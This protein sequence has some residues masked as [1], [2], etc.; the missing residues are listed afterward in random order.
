MPSTTAP[1]L[2]EPF[3]EH[4]GEIRKLSTLLEASQALSTTLD[5]RTGL[6]LVLA[7]LSR[8]HGAVRSTVVLRNERSGDVEVEAS[9]P[10][11]Q[12]SRRIRYSVGEGITRKVLQTGKPV[13]VPRV[14]EEPTFLNRAAARPE[15]PEQELTYI[16]API[17]L[18]GRTIGAIGVDLRF[19]PDRDYHRTVKFLGVVGSMIAQA[20]KLYGLLQAER[21]AAAGREHAPAA[22]ADRALPVLESHRDQRADARRLPADIAGGADHDH[23]AAAW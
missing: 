16:S 6:D 1:N 5:L 14:S 3:E 9:V 4:A 17:D 23:G 19:K 20:V 15:L 7:I 21:P 13:V 12:T 8:H 18:E 11:I 22:R 10:P 2:P